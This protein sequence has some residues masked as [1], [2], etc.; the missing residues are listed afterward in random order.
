MSVVTTSFYEVIT[1][2]TMLI[3]L[4][5]SPKKLARFACAFSQLLQAAGVNFKT[6]V[7]SGDP[8]QSL[9]KFN[10]HNFY[11]PLYYAR[12]AKGD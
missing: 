4:N 8:V 1:T 5:K 6:A 9:R 12:F 11:Y 3:L 7:I 2:G 10:Q